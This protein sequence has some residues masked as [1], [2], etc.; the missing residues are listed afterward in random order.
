MSKWTAQKV[1]L[2]RE[3]RKTAS[4]R[5]QFLLLPFPIFTPTTNLSLEA[6]A[7]FYMLTTSA[8]QRKRLHTEK[9]T[10]AYYL[11]EFSY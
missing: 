3:L 11:P 5:D 4:H 1:D 7:D 10:P 8:W 9:Q 2:D 6:F